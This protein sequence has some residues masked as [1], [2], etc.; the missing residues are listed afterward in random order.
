V[1]LIKPQFEAGRGEVPRGGVIKDKKIHDKVIENIRSGI[2]DLGYNYL[3]QT[4]SP[5]TGRE[6][7]IEFFMYLRKA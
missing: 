3:G 5:I 6:G 7:N 2:A 1:T 4:R